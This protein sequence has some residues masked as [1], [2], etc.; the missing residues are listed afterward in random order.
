MS[1]VPFTC[2]VGMGKRHMACMDRRT[3]Q[4]HL[5]AAGELPRGGGKKC[6]PAGQRRHR[7][8]ASGME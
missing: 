7:Q 2:P 4:M 6:W 5:F 1:V 3:D 8:A